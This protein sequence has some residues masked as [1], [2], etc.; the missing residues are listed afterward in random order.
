M[1]VAIVR[2][3]HR[4]IWNTMENVGAIETQAFW[5]PCFFSMKHIE[6]PFLVES[7]LI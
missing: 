5:I 3:P 4:A 7:L 1:I 6:T 2:A